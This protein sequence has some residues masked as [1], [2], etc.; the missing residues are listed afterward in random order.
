M[1]CRVIIQGLHVGKALVA[2]SSPSSRVIYLE[3]DIDH[4]ILIGHPSNYTCQ[5]QFIHTGEH[6]TVNEKSCIT[7]S[8]A[9]ISSSLLALGKITPEKTVVSWLE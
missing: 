6:Y 9:R 4:S 5:S 2:K 8:V 1:K 7:A 3:S